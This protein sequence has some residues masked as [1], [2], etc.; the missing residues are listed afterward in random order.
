MYVDGRLCNA[1]TNREISSPVGRSRTG[2]ADSSLWV[3][4][5]PARRCL[6]LV[7]ASLAVHFMRVCAFCFRHATNV[8]KGM[9]LTR[10]RI[11]SL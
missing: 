3:R 6:V 10:L 5:L 2:I 7:A 11:T 8:N 9:S 1:F 4:A